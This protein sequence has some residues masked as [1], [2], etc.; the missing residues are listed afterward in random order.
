MKRTTVI[1][2]IILIVAAAL[3][4]LTLFANSQAEIPQ[5][6]P[7]EPA[8]TAQP[9]PR[10]WINENTYNLS[11]LL[12]EHNF[13]PT[14][15]QSIGCN[16]FLYEDENYV[17]S[18]DTDPV[19]FV[20][21]NINTD[22]D[23]S[24]YWISVVKNG[25]IYTANLKTGPATIRLSYDGSSFAN[26]HII[27][28]EQLQQIVQF[29]QTFDY[30]KSNPFDGTGLGGLIQRAE[31]D[32]NFFGEPN[33]SP[34]DLLGSEYDENL[35]EYLSADTLFFN[36]PKF[37]A[38]HGFFQTENGYHFRGIYNRG[39]I[40]ST[41]TCYIVIEDIR[42]MYTTDYV[43]TIYRNKVPHSIFIKSERT[44][45]PDEE[46]GTQIWDTSYVFTKEQ[47]FIFTS[48]IDNYLNPISGPAIIS[49]QLS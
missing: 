35:G 6:K 31:I 26:M 45:L 29:V 14:D 1:A 41:T 25:T 33:A 11:I 43:L 22:D 23:L 8:A 32:R 19:Y 20:F 39:T 46:Y 3:I 36:T 47:F 49:Y 27:S 38:D 18:A 24:L 9:K 44:G 10:E 13:C 4:S 21:Q 15:E 30:E 48:V 28:S 42:R 17:P 12:S 34:I 37:L 40:R 7:E 16:T 5:V 2:V